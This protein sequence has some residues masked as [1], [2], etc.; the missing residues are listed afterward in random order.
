MSYFNYDSDREVDWLTGA[1]F[2]FDRRILDVIGN[3]D[4]RFHMYGEEADF[5]L[6]AKRA[7]FKTWFFHL[8]EAIH[9]LGGSATNLRLRITAHHLSHI[10]FLRKHY[11]GGYGSAL[12]VLKC[13]G[14]LLRVITYFIAGALSLNRSLLQK[15]YYFFLSITE[16]VKYSW[17]QPSILNESPSAE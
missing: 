9:L 6:R 4:E 2:M 5:C 3:L 11:K 12:V 7:G 13:S 8:A 16:L 17:N 10:L 14:I 15:A 1:F